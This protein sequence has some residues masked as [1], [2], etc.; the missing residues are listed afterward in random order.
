[1]VLIKTS[2]KN[3]WHLGCT[4]AQREILEDY[5]GEL[6]ELQHEF[7]LKLLAVKM[8]AMESALRLHGVNISD[9]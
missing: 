3:V 9:P 4:D 7:H 8:D 2:Y 1:M 5:T 6:T